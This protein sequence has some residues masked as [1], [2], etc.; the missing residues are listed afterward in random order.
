MSNINVIE[1]KV[2]SLRHRVY[3]G[4]YECNLRYLDRLNNQQFLT[5]ISS[6]RVE[7]KSG[8]LFTFETVYENSE[9]KET[10]FYNHSINISYLCST[11]ARD[12]YISK[13]LARTGLILLV[14]GLFYVYR[15]A[16]YDMRLSSYIRNSL[17]EKGVENPRVSESGN[18]GGLWECKFMNEDSLNPFYSREARDAANTAC[19]NRWR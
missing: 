19:E 6:E 11:P 17:I 15:L 10:I 3:Y 1:G 12:L 9:V 13:V 2:R 7:A 14:L 16:T 4:S 8:D 5:F 18:H